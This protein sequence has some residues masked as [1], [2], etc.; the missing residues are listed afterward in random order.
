VR[1]TIDVAYDRA[2]SELPPEIRPLVVVR[3]ADNMREGQEIRAALGT[4]LTRHDL[5]WW[6]VDNIA[7]G[8]NFPSAA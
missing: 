3:Y 7:R 2:L 6:K 1:P 4:A 8:L 5:R